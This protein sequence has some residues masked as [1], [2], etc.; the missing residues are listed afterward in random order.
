MQ[1]LHLLV[2]RTSDFSKFM[3]YVHGQG[4]KGVNIFCFYAYV[5][6]RLMVGGGVGQLVERR[7]SSRKVA[8]P[9]F[10]FRCNSTSLCPW[11]R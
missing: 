1:T 3:V 2:Q 4:G 10:D 7:D 5:F 8:K 9:W 11:E 6:Y